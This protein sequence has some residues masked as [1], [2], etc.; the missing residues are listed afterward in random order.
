MSTY[1]S[2]EIKEN[3]GITTDFNGDEGI[4]YTV[5]LGIYQDTNRQELTLHLE[6]LLEQ[7]LENKIDRFAEGVKY[8]LEYLSDLFDGVYET[9]LAKEYDPEKH[10]PIN[11]EE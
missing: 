11:E 5:T 1:H 10:E 9:D 4:S 2:Y 8:A 3:P 7:N 6:N